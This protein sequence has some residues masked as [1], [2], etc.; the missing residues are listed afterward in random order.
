MSEYYLKTPSNVYGGKDCLKNIVGILNSEDVSNILIFT[1]KNIRNTGLVDRLTQYIP[2]V[3]KYQVIDSL[4][5]EPS[6]IDVNHVI[7]KSKVYSADVIIAIG[8]GSVIDVAKLYTVL[9]GADYT[10]EDLI[11]RP[12]IATKSLTSIIIPTTCGTGSEATYNSVVAIPEKETKVGIVAK[13][14]L[15][16]YVILDPQM[17]RNLPNHIL[18]ATGIDALSHCVECYTSKKATPFS[19]MYALEGTK[20][21]L[22]NILTAY[23]NPENLLAKENMMLGAYYGGVAIAGSG[24][25][26]VHALSYPLGGKYHIPHGISNAILLPHVMRFNMDACVK[27]L[28][29]ISDAINPSMVDKSE[30]DKA[31]YVIEQLEYVVKE[32]EIST[33]LNS[34]GV[35]PDDIDFLVE[36]GSMQTRLLKN[37]QKEMSK[38]EIRQIYK[39]IL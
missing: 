35:K 39:K 14:L 10:I 16:D 2:D 28:N 18:A 9:H 24:T 34:Y 11:N 29:R 12:E 21:I 7:E 38:E 8:G 23:S 26:A 32:T 31:N 36:A 22:E 5:A 13:E 33:D 17:I 30:Y 19:D 4:V 1:D 6:Y 3:I 25:T 27:Q 15:P 37:N 20:L